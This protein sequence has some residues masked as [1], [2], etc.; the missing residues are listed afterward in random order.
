MGMP[1]SSDHLQELVSRVFGDFIQEGFLTNIADDFYIGADTVTELK[2]RW[3]QV[4]KRLQ[5]NNL[6]LSATKT[7]IFPTRSVILG[8]IWSMGTLAVSPSH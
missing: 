8:W 2:Q 3:F 5:H 6:T 4:L 1:G 7:L